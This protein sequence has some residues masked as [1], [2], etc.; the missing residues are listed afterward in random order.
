MYLNAQS[1]PILKV[2]ILNQ[3]F[4]ALIDT[5]STISLI[6][7]DVIELV[8]R[9][10]IVKSPYHCKIKGL[11]G[12]SLALESVCLTVS[13]DVEKKRQK[14]ILY[15]ELG[16]HNYSVL[17]GRDFIASSKFSIHLHLGGWSTKHVDV[18]VI[19]FENSKKEFLGHDSPLSTISKGGSKNLC[20]RGAVETTF[21]P[22]SISAGSASSVV[23]VEATSF[24][25]V[26]SMCARADRKSQS[27]RKLGS[28][29]NDFEEIVFIFE[30]GMCE[31]SQVAAGSTDT[32]NSAGSP[33]LDYNELRKLRKNQAWVMTSLVTSKKY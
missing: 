5:G 15:P 20:D 7:S 30:E 18:D 21:S 32:M 31:Y 9:H 26:E 16:Q 13:W 24:D 29:L 8:D 25:H 10:N 12:D 4:S 23:G 14:F 33:H 2:K 17:L 6:S 28:H 3:Y 19:P 22:D 27:L 1:G 11:T